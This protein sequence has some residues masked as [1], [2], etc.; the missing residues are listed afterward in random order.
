[1]NHEQRTPF[2]AIEYACTADIV[3]PQEVVIRIQSLVILFLQSITAERPSIMGL[4]MI[5]RSKENSHGTRSFFG[6]DEP[7]FLSHLTYSRPFSNKKFTKAFVRVWMVLRISYKLLEEG[8]HATQRELFYRLL[9]EAPNYFRCQKQVNDAIQDVV[10]VVKCSRYSLGILASSRGSVTG[11]LL[12]QE[13]DGAVLDCTNTGSAGQVITGDL[14]CIQNWRFQSDARYILVVEKDAIFQRLQE[15]KFF[16]SVPCIIITAKGYPDLASRI[17]LHQL[18]CTFPMFPIVALVDWNPAGLAILCTYKFGSVRMG[19]ETSTYVCD[20][21]W[22]GL[23]SRDIQLVSKE[24]FIPLT[25]KDRQLATS[26]LSSKMLQ[27]KKA[28]QEE[29]THMLE[30]GGRIEIEALYAHGYSFL[31]KYIAQKIVERDYI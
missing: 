7:L 26:L 1:M 16:Y 25:A 5:C 18:R 4:S 11:R 23:R 10:A 22:L 17:F 31:G 24:S 30:F 3:P 13:P 21:K 6:E 14:N 2:H 9:S 15:D 20:V 29:L 27:N 8:K 12:I 28:Y 19:L